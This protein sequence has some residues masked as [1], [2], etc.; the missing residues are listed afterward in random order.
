MAREA[1]PLI[2][3]CCADYGRLP[4]EDL[5]TLLRSLRAA[6]R[7]FT[8]CADLCEAAARHPERLAAVADGKG[9]VVACHARAVAALFRRQGLEVPRIL[10]LR[11]GNLDEI[12]DALG[13]EKVEEG[14][15][16]ST[17]PF[18]GD[19]HAWFPV[20]D[21]DRCSQCGQCIDFCLFGVYARREGRVT[22]VQPEACKT[23]CPACARTC[24]EGAIVFPKHEDP[25]INGGSVE[26]GPVEGGAMKITASGKDAFGKGLYERLAARRRKTRK[27]PLF[28]D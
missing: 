6:R 13:L 3:C 11:G 28:E 25:P 22:V 17:P 15:A 7:P 23:D 5:E 27:T 10:D 26:G 24:P 14:P 20:I 4:R 9:S 12:L 19:W 21:G 16:P 18:E 1:E 8:L 2:L